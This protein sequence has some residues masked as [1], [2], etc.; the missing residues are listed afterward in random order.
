MNPNDLWLVHAAA[1]W[2]MAGLIW[3][4]QVVQYPAFA[5]VGDAEFP[6]FHEHHCRSIAFVVGPLMGVELATGLALWANPPAGLS[7]AW[8]A[9][10]LIPIALNAALT[11]L[12]AAPLHARLSVGDRGELRA[13][14]RVN[15][16]RT[17]LWTWRGVWVWITL[18]GVS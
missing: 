8:L 13:L 10:G 3:I 2:A 17:F 4:V 16:V 15:A 5:R 18:R 14:L 6:S 9:A 1:T 12:R 7:S 11:A